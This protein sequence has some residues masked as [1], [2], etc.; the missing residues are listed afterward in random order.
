MHRM[1]IDLHNH[2][3]ISSHCSILSPEDLIET[4][5]A[6]GLDALCVTD[7]HTIE[8]ATVAQEAGVRMGFPVFRGIE[9]RSNLGDMLVFGYY[10]DIPDG[11]SFEDLCWYVHEVGGLLF[12]AHPF[13]VGGGPS[14]RGALESRHL[15]PDIQWEAV[16]VLR[17][18]D[19]I[20]ILNG[21][22]TDD[23]N[24]RAKL[25][26]ENMQLPG[27]AGSDA[28]SLDMIATAATRFLDPISSDGDLVNALRARRYEPVRLR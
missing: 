24:Y 22:V 28:H 17:Q 16:P 27:I 7:H 19:G 18:L 25:L 1:L 13:H 2:T 23:N 9:A 12:A 21:Q 8:G 11:I 4:A 5:R 14:V 15:D 3:N 26:A 10:K 6:R 20:E